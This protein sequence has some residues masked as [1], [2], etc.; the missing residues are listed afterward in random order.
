LNTSPYGH[1]GLRRPL[2]LD[3]AMTALILGWPNLA[4]GLEEVPH[5]KQAK[6]LLIYQSGCLKV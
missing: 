1:L 2:P 3:F 5:L 4:G 6:L